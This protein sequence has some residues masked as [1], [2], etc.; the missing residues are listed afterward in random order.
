MLISTA[1]LLLLW[2]IIS[3]IV[4]NPVTIPT[5]VDTFKALM[6]IVSDQ[7]FII[8]VIESLKR[9]VI[10][11][12]IAFGFGVVLGMLS[13][14]FTPVYY[15]LKPLMLIQRAIPTM[16]VILLALIWLDREI[17][18]ILVCVLVVLPII[19]SAVVT[20][21]REIDPKLMEMTSIYNFSNRKKLKHLYIPS[22]WTSLVSVSSAAISLNVKIAI[23]A[24]V[25][26]Q[27]KYAI[28][29][30]FVM[31]KVALE[32][33]GVLAWA[34]IAIVLV[35]LFQWLIE[36]GLGKWQINRR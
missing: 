7:Y 26:S 13:G 3:Y 6:R 4:D 15:L 25:L 27:P 5:P 11:F 9:I 22:I 2:G 35:A 10:S 21:V 20:G 29:T 17:A 31:E 16:A 24:E 30:G 34:L 8:R 23:A 32:T 19:Y 18:P 1:A 36:V 28:G 33:A 14:A 12:M